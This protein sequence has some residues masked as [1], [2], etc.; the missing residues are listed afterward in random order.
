MQ[1]TKLRGED[2]RNIRAFL[3]SIAVSLLLRIQ[4]MSTDQFEDDV[5][6]YHERTNC[7][8]QVPTARRRRKMARM[9]RR[10]TPV[11]FISHHSQ[12]TK[13]FTLYSSQISE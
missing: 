6:E 3:L 7:M 5:D 12:D 4:R 10:Q 8:C 2:A 1:I 13:F 9:R 11:L